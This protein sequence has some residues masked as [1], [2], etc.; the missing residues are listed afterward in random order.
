MIRNQY[1]KL[2]IYYDRIIRYRQFNKDTKETLWTINMN[3]PARSFKGVL[4]LFVNQKN[5]AR[6][7]EEFMNPNITKVSVVIEGKPNQ[8]FANGMLPFHQY[9]ECRKLLAGGRLRSDVVD[10]VSKD[11]HLHDTRLDQYLVNKFALWLDFRTIPNNDLHG[12]GRRIDSGTDGVSLEFQRDPDIKSETITVYMYVIMDAQ[13]N[14]E[15]GRLK[16]LV[17]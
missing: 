13:L 2:A 4:M 7:S 10:H 15:N 14:I 11:L 3:S 5:Y 9:D 6:D 8:L 1:D 16:D 17:Y 12:S